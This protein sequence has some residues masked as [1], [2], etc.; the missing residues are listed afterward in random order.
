MKEIKKPKD[1]I[2]ALASRKG[3]VG[4]TPIALSLA[5]D[6]EYFFLTND[7]GIATEVY[8]N[9][10][11]IDK[12]IPVQNSIYD[13]GGYASA[14]VIE[15]VKQSD[16]LIIPVINESDAF[17]KTILTAHELKPYAKET[18]LIATRTE[19]NDMDEITKE[20]RE[21]LPNIKIFELSKSKIFK[22]VTK[23]GMSILQIA[24]ETPLNRYVY[25]KILAEYTELLNYIKKA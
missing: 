12:P 14:G 10:R 24:N 7:R 22:R 6:L 8:S 15:V 11:Y 16:L 23:D 19:K 2:F 9:S 25:R 4:K 13:F 1:K 20:M 5:I 17:V 3:G 18:I 21:R